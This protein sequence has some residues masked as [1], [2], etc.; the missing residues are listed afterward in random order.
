[1]NAVRATKVHTKSGFHWFY[2]AIQAY[3]VLEDATTVLFPDLDCAEKCAAYWTLMDFAPW[4]IG[5]YTE[6]ELCNS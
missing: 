2:E 3:N 1:M 6:E 4:E 5:F